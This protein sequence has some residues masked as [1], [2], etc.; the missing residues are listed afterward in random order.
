MAG[1][2]L[3]AVATLKLLPS[4]KYVVNQLALQFHYQRTTLDGCCCSLVHTMSVASLHQ[5]RSSV[6]RPAPLQARRLKVSVAASSR[7]G[8]GFVNL[9]S[10]MVLSHSPEAAP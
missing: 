7:C 4:T 6:V 3:P 2:P 5:A 10:L 1:S 8:E 9:W